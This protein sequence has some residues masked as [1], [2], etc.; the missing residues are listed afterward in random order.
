MSHGAGGAAA[1]IIVAPCT[2]AGAGERAIIRLSGHGAH[3]LAA[4]TLR[5]QA[6]P[7]PGCVVPAVLELAEGAPLP[8]EVLGWWAPRSLTGE[9]VVEVH[10]PG[11]PAV[12]T[13][14]VRRFVAAGAR[15]AT[16]GEFARR[17][18]AMGKLDLPGVLTLGR[19][20]A[21]TTVEEAAR[22]AEEL[23]EGTTAEHRQLVA[24]LLDALALIEAH[25][26]FEEEDTGA[27]GEAELRPALQRVR[28]EAARMGRRGASVPTRDGEVDVVLLGP[29]NVGKSLLFARLCPDA[30]TTVSPVA[31]TTRDALEARV[32]REGRTFRVIDGPGI[33][34]ADSGDAAMGALDRLAMA[35]FAATL[36]AAAVVL[37]V[38]D[39]A[40]A[41]PGAERA[42]LELVADA[43]R[44]VPV[45]NKIDLV[46]P[47]GAEAS[48]GSQPPSDAAERTVRVSALQGI[49]LDDL[50][51]AVLAVS[52]APGAPDLASRADVDAAAAI[53]PL[54]D[55]A[56]GLSLE[57]ALPTL[58]LAL[59]DAL[60]ILE[61]EED[62]RLDV[63]EEILDRIFAGFCVGK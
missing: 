16:R 30:R 22:A 17:A 36:P 58:S 52:P 23:S 62:R 60:D 29:P 50:W 59:R 48:A 4:S 14:L 6:E 33:L 12:V 20:V 9:D 38:E 3:A 10:L 21:A 56:D 51:R 26:D 2:A 39:A 18:L 45:L 15:P 57:S 53:L 1:E 19:L 42:A 8:V 46:E 63:D 32:V 41:M 13:D 5:L 31:G 61:E 34:A 54:L 27:V 11:W 55:E 44:C 43:R 28:D 47:V 40:T 37:L 35:R 49:G 7:A 24:A 25:V